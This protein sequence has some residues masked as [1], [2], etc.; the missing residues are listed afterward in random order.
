MTLESARRSCNASLIVDPLA[1]A[2]LVLLVVND[3]W[4]KSAWHNEVS[5]KLSDVAVCVLLPLFFAELL[6]PCTR[7]IAQ[8]RILDISAVA[9]AGLYATLELSETAALGAC[10]ALSRVGPWLAIDRPF[11]M[12]RDPSDLWALLAIIPAWLWGRRRIVNQQERSLV[13]AGN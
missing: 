3:T 2:A 4:L 9:T 10:D 11:V 7:W 12:T 1:L 13:H 6:T 8:L 5:G